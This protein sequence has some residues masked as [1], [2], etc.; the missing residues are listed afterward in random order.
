MTSAA[1]AAASGCAGGHRNA[2]VLGYEPHW[3]S[4]VS[5]GG[6]AVGPG[7]DPG[8]GCLGPRPGAPG[9]ASGPGSAGAPVPV[10]GAASTGSAAAPAG[11]GPAARGTLTGGGRQSS[12]QSFGRARRCSGGGGLYGRRECH[13]PTLGTVI[14]TQGSGLASRGAQGRFRAGSAGT[15]EALSGSASGSALATAAAVG[16]PAGTGGAAGCEA[17]VGPRRPPGKPPYAS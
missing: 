15:D 8:S 9:V 10:G 5:A 4:C 7:I 2:S 13:G 1:A 16:G 6:P 11:S 17:S 3:P 12:G 14:G